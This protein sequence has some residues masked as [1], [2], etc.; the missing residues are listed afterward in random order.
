M[1]THN[2]PFFNIHVKKKI[3]LIIPT[4]QPKDFFLGTQAQVETAM[5][6]KPSVFEPLR[7]YCIFSP[8]LQ[9]SLVS[10]HYLNII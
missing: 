1:R 2:I 10:K 6:N 8:T 9:N 7:F 3:T 4:L 5:V